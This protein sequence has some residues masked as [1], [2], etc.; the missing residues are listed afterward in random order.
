MHTGRYEFLSQGSVHFGQPAAAAARELLG[1]H[2]AERILIVSTPSL[3]Q[4][5][6]VVKEISESLE[7]ACIGVFDDVVAHAPLP[8]ILKLAGQIRV[9]KPDLVLTVGGGS[10][11]DTTKVALLAVAAN[12]STSEDV[13]KLKIEVAPDGSVIR[14]Q[15]PALSVRQA[16]VPT[17]LSGAEFGTIGG[18][19][20]PERGVKDI[21]AHPD[22]CAT[23]VI[24]DPELA[25]LTPNELWTSTG[26]RAVDH[27][28][29]TI[30]SK[31]AQPFTDGSALHALRL[32]QSSLRAGS[33]SDMDTDTLQS[34]QFGVWLATVGLGRVPYGASHGIGHQLGA[35]AGVP[36]GL[37]SCVLLPAVLRYNAA[38]AGERDQWISD[39]MGASGS[40]SADA[41]LA[42]VRRLG[43][44]DNLQAV[45]VEKSQFDVIAE[46]SLTNLFVRNNLRPLTHKDQIIE[47][48]ESAWASIDGPSGS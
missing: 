21:Y 27:A 6:N 36:H 23:S 42:L 1:E 41:V 38:V 3:S 48:L 43:L 25:K 35:V 34:C 37:C 39:A 17:T 2:G 4:R 28:V 31:T 18:A 32:F 11:I 46:A 30:L 10:V 47:I 45:G 22:L 26:M 44:T 19:V 40:S 24:Y 13:L 8:N 29:E 14:P 20:D 7:S 15:L 5:A 12:A 33:Q 16:A 9:L